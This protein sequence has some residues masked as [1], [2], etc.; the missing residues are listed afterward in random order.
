[1][2]QKVISKRQPYGI[3]FLFGSLSEI[4]NM[5]IVAENNTPFHLTLFYNN[6]GNLNNTFF[7]KFQNFA[8]SFEANIIY[9]VVLHIPLKFSSALM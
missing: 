2:Q 1:M 9:F 3:E 4:K 7:C 5:I 6:V 8:K